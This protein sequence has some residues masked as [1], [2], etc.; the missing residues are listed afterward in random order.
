MRRALALTTLAAALACAGCRSGRPLGELIP[1]EFEDDVPATEEPYDYMSGLTPASIVL[2]PESLDVRD[3][4]FDSLRAFA[5]HTEDGHVRVTGE[6]IT[7]DPSLEDAPPPVTRVRMAVFLSPPVGEGLEP[8]QLSALLS[9][10]P[11]AEAEATRVEPHVWTA[12]FR[13]PYAEVPWEAEGAP[14]GPPVAFVSVFFV[15]ENGVMVREL[16]PAMIEPLMTFPPVERS[17]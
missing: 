1:P 4:G 9:E 2:M 15:H 14:E 3:A 5:A 6:L 12:E 7:A 11:W 16:W 10:A 13:V 17:P 8:A